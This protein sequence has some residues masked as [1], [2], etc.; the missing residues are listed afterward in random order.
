MRGAGL[1]SLINDPLLPA[2]ARDPE[3]WL[4][5]EVT[6]E[7]SRIR[8]LVGAS[9][10]VAYE[11]GEGRGLRIGNCLRRPPGAGPA[12]LRLSYAQP[13]PAQ[14]ARSRAR[15]LEA[16][17]SDSL[18]PTVGSLSVPFASPGREVA[19]RQLFDEDND[20]A[21][22]ELLYRQARQVAEVGGEPLRRG[23]RGRGAPPE[24]VFHDE[25]PT[26]REDA[27]AR[28]LRDED[29]RG[30]RQH[31]AGAM[32]LML[33]YLGIPACVAAGFTSGLFDED[34]GRRTVADT[35]AHTWVE[36]WFDGYGWLPSDPT[37]GRR[38]ARS[39]RRRRSSSTPWAPP[40]HSPAVPR[41]SG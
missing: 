39:T 20:Q 1:D 22:Y 37:P 13:T 11:E 7:A 38:L 26:V 25:T 8:H 30:Y 3:K 18:F 24:R 31:F 41:R 33:R 4:W 16:I 19:L 32:A 17:M 6:I 5:Q 40:R 35:N 23:G 29:R 9:V 36:V 27:A 14:L 15:Y 2:G 34:E 28:L 21:Q 10:P 12:L